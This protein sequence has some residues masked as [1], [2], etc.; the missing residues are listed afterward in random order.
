[1]G[2]ILTAAEGAAQVMVCAVF[3]FYFPQLIDNFFHTHIMVISRI[4]L[5]ERWGIW[6]ELSEAAEDDR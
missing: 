5:Y 6:D 3:A 4:Q 2:P 1:M